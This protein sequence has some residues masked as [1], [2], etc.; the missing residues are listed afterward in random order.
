MT[1]SSR[2]E[3]IKTFGHKSRQ[4]PSRKTCLP[5]SWGA[6][7]LCEVPHLEPST[8]SGQGVTAP[9]QM[10]RNHGSLRGAFGNTT[11]L[12]IS[13]L[14]ELIKNRPHWGTWLSARRG[15]SRTME[16]N[17][18]R[19]TRCKVTLVTRGERSRMVMLCYC[20]KPSLG[21][22]HLCFMTYIHPTLRET[23]TDTLQRKVQSFDSRKPGHFVS[24]VSYR[25][26]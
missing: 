13:D 3:L 14:K 7:M 10:S 22:F 1:S 6:R 26:N 25:I 18:R 19:V 5:L 15:L 8:W 12:A 21:F 2:T 4:L 24:K 16:G 17:G 23:D 20:W 9:L 11:H